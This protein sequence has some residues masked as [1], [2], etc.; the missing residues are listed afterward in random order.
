MDLE[1]QSCAMATLNHQHQLM[2]YAIILTAIKLRIFTVIRS[3][4]TFGGNM[5]CAIW[6][7]IQPDPQ[8]TN[9][10]ILWLEGTPLVIERVLPHWKSQVASS[11]GASF[12]SPKFCSINI[13]FHCSSASRTQ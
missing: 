5:L 1:I 12:F 9:S 13:R 8:S 6:G 2:C 10:L 11:Q 7:Q 3:Y 4:S